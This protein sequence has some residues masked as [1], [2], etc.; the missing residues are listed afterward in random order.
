MKVYSFSKKESVVNNNGNIKKYK[1]VV[2]HDGKKGIEQI[3]KN[4]KV[5][6]RRLSASSRTQLVG[7]VLKTTG[8]V[9]FSVVWLYAFIHVYG[10]ILSYYG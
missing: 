1:R 2:Q 10:Q 7:K 6:T 5:K 3:E 9:V 8:V 4:G